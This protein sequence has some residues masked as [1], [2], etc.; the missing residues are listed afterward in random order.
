MICNEKRVNIFLKYTVS[1]MS[2]FQFAHA[3]AFTCMCARAYDARL[4]QIDHLDFIPL[5]RRKKRLPATWTTVLIAKTMRMG[6][7]LFG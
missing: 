7:F 5:T 1:Y 3:R 2:K 6:I 4:P